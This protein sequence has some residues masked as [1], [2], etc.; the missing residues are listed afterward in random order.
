MQQNE[1]KEKKLVEGK[2]VKELK[3][4]GIFNAKGNPK[5]LKGFPDRMIFINKHIIFVECKAGKEL[6]SYYNQTP[7][8]KKWEKQIQASGQNYVLVVGI[9]GVSAFMKWLNE[10]VELYGKINC[11]ADTKVV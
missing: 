8:Q 7:M 9:S 4:M 11:F 10:M 5:Q 2:L 6:G 1:Q 3:K